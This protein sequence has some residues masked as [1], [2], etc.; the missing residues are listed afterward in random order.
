MYV[1][2]YIYFDIHLYPPSASST[3]RLRC[4]AEYPGTPRHAH[5]TLPFI[6]YPLAA[7]PC[8]RASNDLGTFTSQRSP[9]PACFSLALSPPP[10]R[11]ILRADHTSV[12]LIHLKILISRQPRVTK[13]LLY[14]SYST[15]FD[16][17]NLSVAGDL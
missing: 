3:L 15:N 9:P 13:K 17:Q 1:P 4:A 10:R 14:P 2:K 11:P 7:V 5:G 6:S 8:A 12:A 16:V